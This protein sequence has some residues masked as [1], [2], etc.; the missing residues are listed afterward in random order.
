M[1]VRQMLGCAAAMSLHTI[2]GFLAAR[3]VS[4]TTPVISAVVAIHVQSMCGDVK[5]KMRA[6]RNFEVQLLQMELR[7]A[8]IE[9]RRQGPAGWLA[10][11][12]LTGLS[13]TF[14]CETT[15]TSITDGLNKLSRLVEACVDRKSLKP[16]DIAQ[17]GCN[18]TNSIDPTVVGGSIRPPFTSCPETGKPITD[19]N[20]GEPE[21]AQITCRDKLSRSTWNG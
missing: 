20:N 16:Y 19:S 10:S 15:F 5:L 18:P 3:L 2:S 11:F 12:R 8:A 1:A 4:A 14:T 21:Q 17:H 7:Q 6:T 13:P 9:S